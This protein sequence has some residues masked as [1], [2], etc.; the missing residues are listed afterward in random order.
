MARKFYSADVVSD[1]SLGPR[2]IRVELTHFD[3]RRFAEFLAE[4]L[5]E[6]LQ[7]FGET[8]SAAE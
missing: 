7:A 1:A 8:E 3:G 2:E 4:R 6:L 5:P